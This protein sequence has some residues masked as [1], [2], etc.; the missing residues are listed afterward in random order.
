M[1]TSPITFVR[2]VRTELAKVVW[3]TRAETIKL[4]VVVIAVSV[5]IGLFIGALDIMFVKMTE[6]LIK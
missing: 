1:A 6:L 5:G 3:P 2:Q 4:T